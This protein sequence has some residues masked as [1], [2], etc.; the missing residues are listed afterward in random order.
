MAFVPEIAY[1]LVPDLG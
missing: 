1:I